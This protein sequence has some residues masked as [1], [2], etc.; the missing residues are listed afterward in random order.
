MGGKR[1]RGTRDR[2]ISAVATAQEGVVSLGQLRAASLSPQA[3]SQR[4]EVARLHR[5]VYAVGHEKVS[6]CGRLL[7]AT[8]ACG[9]GSAVSHFSAAAFWRLRGP[10]PVVIDVVVPCE[11][12]RKIDG[13]RARRCRYPTPEELTSHQGVP[14]TTPSRTLVDLAGVLGHGPLKRAV[15]QAFVETHGTPAAFQSDRRRD[16]VLMSAG[17][18]V[19]RV[20]WRQAI[21]EPE[22]WRRGSP[23]CSSVDPPLTWMAPRPP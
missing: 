7:A 19:A 3:V 13:I 4:A 16:Q 6:E 22:G 11:T 18:R 9:P 10:M 20:T 17:Y 2:L 1:N 12:G 8:L 23:A 14:C 21:D 15:E 5:G